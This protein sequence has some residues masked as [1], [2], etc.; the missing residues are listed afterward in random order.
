M[1]N[2][3]IRCGKRTCANARQLL[4]LASC[5]LPFALRVALY[6]SSAGKPDQFPCELLPTPLLAVR[7]YC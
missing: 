5:L 6:C 2:L 4:P 3:I 7:V 1:A